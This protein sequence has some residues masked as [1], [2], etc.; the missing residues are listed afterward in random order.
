MILLKS[1]KTE[2]KPE[3]ASE[4]EESDQSWYESC[5]WNVIG[6]LAT[7]LFLEMLAMA[8]NKNKLIAF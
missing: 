7:M 8:N 6:P 2:K 1:I 3:H 5:K 4:R